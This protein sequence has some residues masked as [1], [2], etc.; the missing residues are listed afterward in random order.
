MALSRT[1]NTEYLSQ[2]YIRGDTRK[3]DKELVKGEVQGLG[4]DE[5]AQA[6]LVFKRG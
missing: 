6:L 5:E 1:L 4:L 3:M 2:L